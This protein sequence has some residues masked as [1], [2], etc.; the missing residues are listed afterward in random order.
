MQAVEPAPD[1][2]DFAANEGFVAEGG[3]QNRHPLRPDQKM[4]RLRLCPGPQ[5]EGAE[6]AG[7][8]VAE[9][10]EDLC[11]AGLRGVVELGEFGTQRSDRAAEGHDLR[12]IGDQHADETQDA[13]S[14]AAAGGL[15]AVEHLARSRHPARNDGLEDLVLGLEMVIEIPARDANRRGDV[16]KGRGFEAAFVEQEIRFLDDEVS[17]GT[18]GHGVWSGGGVSI[19]LGQLS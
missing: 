4:H 11:G 13:L 19:S 2:G 12:A 17:G 6:L 3:G 7:E 1:V 8:P 9:Q 5:A 16:G 18:A 15:P 10:D 14:R